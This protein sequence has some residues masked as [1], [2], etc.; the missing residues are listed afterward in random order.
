MAMSLWSP[1]TI[2]PLW[3]HIPGASVYVCQHFLLEEHQIEIELMLVAL[4]I[5]RF[6]KGQFSKMVT[7]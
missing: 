5:N 1:H 7:F 6:F 3:F 4:F 2:F